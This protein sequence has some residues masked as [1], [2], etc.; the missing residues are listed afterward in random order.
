MGD[1]GIKAGTA[2]GTLLILLVQVPHGDLVRTAV[3]A[4]TGA[5]VSYTVS[6]VIKLL[7]SWLKRKLR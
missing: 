5:I 1:H 7:V 6:L 4:G 3:L 2:G